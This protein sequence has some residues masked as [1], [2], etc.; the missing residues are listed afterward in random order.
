[1]DVSYHRTSV[2]AS[3][4]DLPPIQG[5]GSIGLH[6][7]TLVG[8]GNQRM[9]LQ[10]NGMKWFSQISMELPSMKTCSRRTSLLIT[11]SVCEESLK[12]FKEIA[13]IGGIGRVA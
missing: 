8:Q 5:E 1:M 7:Q 4:Q 9:R 11:P 6:T 13:Q 10:G 2:I 3:S 12:R